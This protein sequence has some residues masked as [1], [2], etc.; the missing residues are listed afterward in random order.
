M[1]PPLGVRTHYFHGQ[2]VSAHGNEGF[3][4]PKSAAHDISSN[5]N[6]LSSTCGKPLKV[7]PTPSWG[8]ADVG[9]YQV[10]SSDDKNHKQIASCGVPV[11]RFAD[12]EDFNIVLAI[13]EIDNVDPRAAVHKVDPCAA[14]R[15]PEVGPPA[16]SSKVQM[17]NNLSPTDSSTNVNTVNHA[18]Q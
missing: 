1:Q 15:S 13:N 16:N 7:N 4:R 11:C 9:D 14:V 18:W 17:H 8:G 5:N 10:V 6:N 3:E 2:A 12:D